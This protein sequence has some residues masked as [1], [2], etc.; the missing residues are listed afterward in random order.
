MKQ[1]EARGLKQI[2]TIIYQDRKFEEVISTD[3][4]S[5]EVHIT[6][7]SYSWDQSV[8]GLAWTNKY[9][10]P[11]GNKRYDGPNDICDEKVKKG[12]P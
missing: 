12:R 5:Q 10:I 7:F 1:T 11:G 8:K 2:M 3:Y 4:I 9:Q 6:W